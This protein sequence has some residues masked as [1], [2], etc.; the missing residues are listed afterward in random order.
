MGELLTKTDY[1]NYLECGCYLWMAKKG[2]HLLPPFS[3][4]ELFHQQEGEKVDALAKQLYRKGVELFD[5]NEEGWRKS[6]PLFAAKEAVIFQPTV[7]TKSGLTCRADIVTYDQ[8]ADAYD[9]REVKSATTVRPEDLHDVAFQ[10]VC[11]K[12]AGIKVGKAYILHVNSQY[13]RHG[14]IAP[15]EFFVTEEVTE[16]ARALVPEVKKGIADSLALLAIDDYPDDRVIL[17]CKSK[18]GSCDHLKSY[19]S[20]ASAPKLD[21]KAWPPAFALGLL[22]KGVLDAGTLPSVL[23]RGLGFTPIA[24]KVDV[25]LI[26]RELGAL[27]YPVYFL[28]Y[29]TYASP[30]P[31]FDGTR[32]WQKIVFQYSLCIKKTPKSKPEQ[33]SFLAVEDRNPVPE[34]VA[35]LKKDIGTNGTVIVWY[36]PF[37][38]PRNREIGQQYPEFAEFLD[39]LNRRVYDLMVIFKE[40]LY[41]DARFHGSASIKSVLPVIVPDLSYKTLAIQEGGTASSSWPRLTDSKTPPAEKEKLRRDML[42]YCGRDTMAMVRILEHLEAAVR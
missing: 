31:P 13:V 21:I 26:K 17:S 39:S 35:Q 15:E 10:L 4:S 14:I 29:E 34:M 36:A 1:K 12:E 41:V 16:E 3:A 19:L 23:L 6:K 7:I 9:L 40:K 2:K 5:F 18:T 38:V 27:V 24:K 20:Q 8:K 32:P 11:F 25:A 37:E 28:D 22:R 42:L 30:I 33:R